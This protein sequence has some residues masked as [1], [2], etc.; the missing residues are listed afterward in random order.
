MVEKIAVCLGIFVLIF[1]C[2]I[3][4]QLFQDVW[5]QIWKEKEGFVLPSV[6]Y[7]KPPKMKPPKQM[8]PK[9]YRPV[10]WRCTLPVDK[11]TKT[12]GIAF[13]VEGNKVIRLLLDLDSARALSETISDYLEDHRRWSRSHSDKSEGMSSSAGSMPEDSE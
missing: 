11:N 6:K 1:V 3:L 4:I 5:R 7:M 10:G 9:E 8:I 12:M 2:H 13:N